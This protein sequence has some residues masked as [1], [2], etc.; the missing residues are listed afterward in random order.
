[1]QDTSLVV[2]CFFD[3]NDVV[4]IEFAVETPTFIMLPVDVS[5]ESIVVADMSSM[6]ATGLLIDVHLT[7]LGEN[8]KIC[9]F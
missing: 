4:F 6:F 8:D 1:M 3:S 2:V 7:V 5:V 9:P